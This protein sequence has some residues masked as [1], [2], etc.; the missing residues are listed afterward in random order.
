LALANWW[1]TAV[2]PVQIPSASAL[3]LERSQNARHA[4]TPLIAFANPSF[5]GKPSRQAES[6]AVPG[7]R[8]RAFSGGGVSADFDYRRVS[9]LP[10]TLDEARAIASALGAPEQNVI[11]G[12]QASRSSVM[13]QD[14]SADR[15]V[16][17]ATHGIVAGEVPGMR[18]AGLALAYEGN[19][20][21]DSILTVDDIVALRLNADWVVLSACNTGFTSGD[22]GDSISAMSRG[23]F[24]AGARSLLVTQWAV[25][26][27]SAKQ[28]TVGMFKAYSSD[29]SLSKADA[30]AQV[31]RDMLSG[32]NG[33]LYRHPY[34]WAPFFLSGDAAR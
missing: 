16:L 34:F 22:A 19:G 8:E 25:E 30:I 28:L 17:F 4:S 33:T 9:P 13:K 31:Q 21:T 20:L 27:E 10:E 5:D 11:W 14:L 23:F 12:T 2:T 29:P 15:V 3:V 26:S 7:V 24:A 6:G 32:K 1:I 18:K